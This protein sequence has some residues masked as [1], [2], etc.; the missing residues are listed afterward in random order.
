MSPERIIVQIEC[1]N[2][3]EDTWL[4]PTEPGSELRLLLFPFWTFWTLFLHEPDVHGSV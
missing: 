2:E 4:V 1:N 3:Q